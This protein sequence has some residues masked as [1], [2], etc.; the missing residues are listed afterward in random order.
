ME[1]N[2]QIGRLLDGFFKGLSEHF[3]EINASMWA[4]LCA[5][6]VL[7]DINNKTGKQFPPSL[8][9]GKARDW[10][11]KEVE[12]DV[13]DGIIGHLTRECGRNVH[14]RHVVHITCGSFE[15]ETH[16]VNP[17]SG[18]YDDSSVYGAKNAADL[19]SGSVFL[20][21]YRSYQEDVPRTRNNWVCETDWLELDRREKGDSLKGKKVTRPFPLSR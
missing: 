17:H 18:A 15:K 19:E 9:K 5:R 4:S 21:A 11:E 6:L 20:S 1:M 2:R 10:R 14:D 3:Y 13:P 12:I 8:K 16:E 7:P